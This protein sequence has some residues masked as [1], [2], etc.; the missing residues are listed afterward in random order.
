M[1]YS[2]FDAA[3]FAAD[4]SFRAW[5]L[6][7]TDAAFWESWAP[8]HPEKALVLQQARALVLALRFRT[9]EVSMEEMD[10][11]K[12]QIDQLLDE[13]VIKK[14]N[15]VSR[16]IWRYAMGVAAAGL[17]LFAGLRYVQ[18]NESVEN[19]Y[20]QTG[21]RETKTV[22]LP[23]GSVVQLNAN[24]SLSY[25]GKWTKEKVRAVTL[26]GEAYFKVSKSPA[27][28]HPKFRVL[29][30][31]VTI[32]VKGTAFN[33]YNRHAEVKVLLEE[34]KIVV[35]DNLAMKPGDIMSFAHGEH[36][37]LQADPAQLTAWKEH[38]LMFTD[39]PLQQVAQQLEDIYGYK[40][41]F[42]NKRMES[43][44]FTG[45]GSAADPSMLL[46]A[47]ATVHQ[48]KMKQNNSV[49]IFE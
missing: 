14:N 26:N 44:L 23:D 15:V 19:I 13:P 3:D 17:L 27:G 43:L 38:R 29:M 41:Q 25:P 18:S 24:S 21:F 8:V 46:K 9:N 7:E 1:N 5:V 6:D 42:R 20:V 40:I 36:H 37:R 33:V 16:N 32:E 48:L 28:L 31:D 12:D 39:T 35:N 45:S 47:M 11:V 4:P 10:A 22:Y 49:I 2:E 30:P 34:G